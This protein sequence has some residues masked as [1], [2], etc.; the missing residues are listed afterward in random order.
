M[1][2]IYAEAGSTI[3]AVDA[4]GMDKRWLSQL[5]E[6]LRPEYGVENHAEA[7]KMGENEWAQA[8]LSWFCDANYWKRIWIIQEFAISHKL[9][10][11]VGDA[12][13][14]EDKL[15]F[16]IKIWEHPSHSVRRDQVKAVFEIR[17][18]WKKKKPIGL[19]DILSRTKTS[20]CGRRHDRVFG[21]IGL[22]LDALEFVSEP[23]YQIDWRELATHMTRSYVMK[24]SLDLIL[25][26]SRSSLDLS[27]ASWSPNY[28]EFDKCPPEERCFK[29]IASHS[30]RNELNSLYVHRGRWAATG[31]SR[32]DFYF[33]GSS[34][35]TSAHRIGE[36]YSLSAA[37]SDPTDGAYP[38]HD[39][40]MSKYPRDNVAEMLMSAMLTSDNTYNYTSPAPIHGS[41]RWIPNFL[42]I[43]AYN[44]VLSYAYLSAFH[45]DHNWSDTDEPLPGIVQ[46][47]C[48]NRDFVAAGRSLGEYAA[49]LG[50]PARHIGLA[51]WHL[52]VALNKSVHWPMKRMAEANMRMMCLDNAEFGIGWAALGARVYDEVFL[53]PGVSSP[54]VLRRREDGRYYFIG[55]AVVIGA[56]EGEVWKGVDGEELVKVE[57]V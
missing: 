48:R 31:Y 37:W 38:T 11:L 30:P 2:Y 51:T 44:F 6:Y 35:V 27:L 21:L 47:L 41:Y 1:R 43:P 23:N 4:E 53:V 56:M 3:V 33:S 14:T 13:I 40:L 19:L 34:L 32:G 8:H 22:S 20:L 42:Q 52:S 9:L 54:V 16:L 39:P 46:W 45:P 15:S 10:F 28:F 57:I 7:V 29:I 55:D 5:L 50:H 26:A 24:H 18:S 49:E 17:E 12:L 25:L 36:I